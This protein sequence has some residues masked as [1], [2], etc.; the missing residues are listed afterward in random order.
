MIT[1]FNLII[2]R[3]NYFWYYINSQLLYHTK[4]ILIKEIYFN[5]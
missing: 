2:L 4:D 5:N 1:S 3:E